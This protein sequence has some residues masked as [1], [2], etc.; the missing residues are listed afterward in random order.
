LW[1]RATRAGLAL[2]LVYGRRS[3]VVPGL[4]V[5]G[6][7]VPGL[8]VPGLVGPGLTVAGVNSARD[9]RITSAKASVSRGGG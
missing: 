4:V 1:L 6:L 5:P 8:V 3:H 7:V 2:W 9:S